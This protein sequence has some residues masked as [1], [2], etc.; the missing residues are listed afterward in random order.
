MVSSVLAAVF[1]N[2][3]FPYV[4]ELYSKK[5]TNLP[6]YIYVYYA[7][8]THIWICEANT[9]NG[10]PEGS[11]LNYKCLVYNNQKLDYATFA[12]RYSSFIQIWQLPHTVHTPVWK[13][14]N[15]KH[16]KQCK[17]CDATLSS[18]IEHIYLNGRCSIC[19]KGDITVLS[20][21]N[22]DAEVQLYNP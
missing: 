2:I 17:F 20:V 21:L 3:S 10:L 14:S 9:N 6:H 15:Y 4:V 22:T 18:P 13:F 5:Q 8:D 19:G 1:Q 12:N 11:S 7:D 16:W